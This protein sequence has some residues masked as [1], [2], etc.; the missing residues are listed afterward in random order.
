M[1]RLKLLIPSSIGLLL[2]GCA[3]TPECNNGDIYLD[4]R[5]YP[6]MVI[7]ENA[8]FPAPDT[9]WDIPPARP[10][11]EGADIRKRADGR[12]LDEP[13]PFLDEPASP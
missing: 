4:A 12:C 9:T 5:E 2:V 1:S 3:S 8:S 13:P 7:P 11:A 10:V 6:P